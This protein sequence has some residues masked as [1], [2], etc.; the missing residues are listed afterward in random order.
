MCVCAVF[1]LSWFGNSSFE[2]FSFL[3]LLVHAGFSSSSL[4]FEVIFLLGVPALFGQSHS[5][6]T[7]FSCCRFGNSAPYG[8]GFTSPD[9]GETASIFTLPH[10]LIRGLVALHIICRAQPVSLLWAQAAHPEA[11][12]AGLPGP[13]SCPRPWVTHVPPAASFTLD[14][15]GFLLFLLSSAVSFKNVDFELVFLCDGSGRGTGCIN[16]GPH[17][18]GNRPQNSISPG[19]MFKHNFCFK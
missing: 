16:P 17:I 5:D 19:L 7:P 13:V 18:L 15:W 4:N 9:P 14:L 11:V 6:S 3:L 8:W 10:P 12:W 1:P 2:V